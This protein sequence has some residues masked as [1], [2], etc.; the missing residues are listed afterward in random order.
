MDHIQQETVEELANKIEDIT[1]LNTMNYAAALLI[2]E[3]TGKMAKTSGNNRRG[4][5]KPMPKWRADLLIKIAEI[6]KEISQMADGSILIHLK[7]Y[8][9]QYR[10]LKENITY[11]VTSWSKIYCISMQR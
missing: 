5:Q 9:E 11:K 4:K 1:E 2:Q 8:E 3:K 7:N 6:R 10:K